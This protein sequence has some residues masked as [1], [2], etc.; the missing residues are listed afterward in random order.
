MNQDALNEIIT[1]NVLKAASMLADEEVMKVFNYNQ[2]EVLVESEQDG[3]AYYTEKAQDVFND[4]YDYFEATLR[5]CEI[6][7]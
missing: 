5:N 6:K 7:D 1:I 3:A 4:F 2:D